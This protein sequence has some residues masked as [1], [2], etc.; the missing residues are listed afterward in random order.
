M[1]EPWSDQLVLYAFLLLLVQAIAIFI[2]KRVLRL[3]LVLGC[4]VAIWVM[5][6]YVWSLPAPGPGEGAD[7]GGGIMVLWA[8][9]TVIVLA[10]AALGE[11]IR[12]AARPRRDVND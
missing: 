11:G 3:V 6:L 5:A 9:G 1:E 7:I 10:A 4:F 8:I 2:P 12:L